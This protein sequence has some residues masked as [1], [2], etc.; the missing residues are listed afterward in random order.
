[1]P[2]HTHAF[3]PDLPPI[4]A[5]DLNRTRSEIDTDLMMALDASARQDY[6][7]ASTYFERLF[8]R[9][10]KR[11]YIVE[12][13]K[14]AILAKDFDH[15]DAL[16]KKG[17][18]HFKEDPELQR[19]R[20]AYYMDRHRYKKA[21]E[22]IDTLL[23]KERTPRDLE[24][25]AIAARALHEPQK[26]YR[27]LDEAYRMKKSD[28]LVLQLADLLYRDLERKSEAIRLL[29]SHSRIEG[30][31]KPVCYKLIR[32]YAQ[33]EATEPLR[34]VYARLYDTTK[35][36]KY[37]QK[38]IELYLYRNEFSKAI[39]Y[40][41]RHHLGDDLLLDLYTRQ[42]R[43]KEAYRLAMKLYRE[44]K[45]A[46]YLARAAILE[47]EGAGRSKSPKLLKSVLRKFK[48]AMKE[49]DDPLFENY[50]GYLLIDH[51]IDVKQGIEWVKKALKQEPGA[52]YY[53]DSLAWGYY[54]LGRCEEAYKILAPLMPKTDE[55]EI[56]N[57]FEQIEKCRGKSQ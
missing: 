7:T 22:I 12:A 40:V 18:A 56:E 33:Q 28:R 44:H 35:D 46:H 21:R 10:G 51:D 16:L 57:H 26:A 55:P 48:K 30:C 17:L 8:D 32:I 37:A 13:V 38:V 50:Y 36:P 54:K 52:L 27:Y 4:V 39:R 42:K 9:T 3:T 14:N 47:Y 11:E 23:K 2:L 19:Y 29:E 34:E 31:S 25:A 41:K 24:L 43:Y 49:L 5:A 45:A 6:R 1:M 53:L 20:A 15:I